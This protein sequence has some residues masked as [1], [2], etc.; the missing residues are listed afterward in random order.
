MP[1]YID[2]DQF[3]RKIKVSR[4]FSRAGAD[5]RLLRSVALNLLN[6]VPTADVAPKSEAAKEIFAEI[7]ASFYYEFIDGEKHL[8]IRE[9]DYSEIKKQ[10]TEGGAKDE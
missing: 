3:A 6:T 10:Y 7:E 2:A 8:I 4:A 9:V 5:G 1:R